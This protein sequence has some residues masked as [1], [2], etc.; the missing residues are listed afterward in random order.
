MPQRPC[1]LPW[2]TILENVTLVQELQHKPNVERAKEWLE[3]VGLVFYPCLPERTVWRHAAAVCPLFEQWSVIS[4]F[5][6]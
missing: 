3:K 6:A 1:L 5:Y 4:R 2:R